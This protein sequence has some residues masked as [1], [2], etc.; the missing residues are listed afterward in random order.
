MKE[1]IINKTNE[2]QRLD[3]YLKRI[4]PSA[5][6][7]FIYKMLRKKNIELNSKRAKGDEILKSNDS[8][9]LFFSDETFEKMTGSYKNVE[10]VEFEEAFK[11]IKGVSVVFEH[12]DF[13]ILYK[14]ENVLTQ[15]ENNDTLSLNEWGIGY[16]LSTGV[17]DTE[18]LREFK[19]SV[20]NRLD[21]NTKGLVIFG[22]TLKGSQR[23]SEMIKKRQMKKY[24]FAKTEPG[25]DLNGIYK[26]YLSKNNKTNK[27]SI[28]TNIDDIP[29]GVKY[30]PIITGIKVLR[31]DTECSLL[32]IDLI[33][34]KS[35]QIRSHLS[36]LGF[37]LLGDAKYNGRTD[38]T[39]KYQSLC[40]YKI[41]F[42]K[43]TDEDWKS[44][45]DKTIQINVDK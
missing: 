28:Y 15:K 12:E 36:S 9:K 21:R 43:I 18:S 20:L 2:N 3:K 42:P 8:V 41:V 39:N 13:M 7:A 6:N 11:S 38:K 35:H 29:E 31:S 33:T 19:P 5:S 40:A 10:I 14:P 34:G 37:P 17:T 1:F 16:L 27:V 25:C 30:S 26:A 45:S 23:L 4:M 22:K 44:L 24:Y 32:E